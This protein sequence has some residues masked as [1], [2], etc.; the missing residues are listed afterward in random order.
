MKVHENQGKSALN[1]KFRAPK[2]INT[3]LQKVYKT[4]RRTG[5]Q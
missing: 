5:E 4:V 2:Q 1:L 3:A